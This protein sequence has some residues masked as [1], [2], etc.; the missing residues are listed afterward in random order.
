MTLK[1]IGRL[2]VAAFKEWNRDKAPRMAA[3]LA[4]YT[5]FS[6]APLLLL[7]IAIAGL[8]I[9]QDAAQSQILDQFQALLGEQGAEALQA[10]I[11]NANQSGSGVLASII[12]VVALLFG[13]SGVFAQLQGALN[14]AWEVKA[15]PKLG[16]WAFIRS[17]FLSFSMVLVIAFL[18]VVS[19]VVSAGLAALN[20]FT[21]DLLPGAEA[22]WQL[23]NFGVSLGI[24]ALLFAMIFK[25]LPD[26]KIAWKDV[27]VGSWVTAILFA[28][29]KFALGFYIGNG[30]VGSTYGAASFLLVLLVW[31]YYSAQI[32][33]FGAELTQVYAS[34]YGSR[35]VPQD[36][37]V[38]TQERRL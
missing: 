4:Y 1:K 28:V 6:L 38:S 33:F 31:V 19:L 2:L 8:F 18:L 34:R 9:G 32:L 29:G 27:W 22:L 14:S 16:I 25:I 17:R 37:A 23:V 12:S 26:A 13:V 30:S 36:Y 7:V 35:I 5:V 10:A 20:E 21:N 15:K 11:A 24:L 3:A